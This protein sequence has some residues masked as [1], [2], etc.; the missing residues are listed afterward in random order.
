MV[1][2]TKVYKVAVLTYV[3]MRVYMY[4]QETKVSKQ[5]HGCLRETQT[6]SESVKRQETSKKKEVVSESMEYIGNHM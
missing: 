4:A 6:E 1:V 2:K 3:Y 5:W